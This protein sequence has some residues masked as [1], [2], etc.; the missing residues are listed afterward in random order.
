MKRKIVYIAV[1]VGVIALITGM[2]FYQKS[3]INRNGYLGD[4]VFYFTENTTPLADDSEENE[5]QNESPTK[6]P[7]SESDK[8]T[9]VSVRETSEP[10]N[11]PKPTP[12]PTPTPY[13]YEKII[14]DEK[15]R[16]YDTGTALI[17]ESAYEL[18]NYVGSSASRYAK[19]INT[20]TKKLDSSV[21]V[22]AMVAPTSMGITFPDNKMK[23]VNSSDQKEALENIEK[24][25]SGRE[26]FVPLYDVMMQRRKEYIYFRTDH[27][28]TSLGAYYAYRA[29]CEKKGILPHELSEYKKTSAGDFLGT[30]YRDTNENTNLRTDILEVYYPVNN[31]KLSMEYTTVE[32]S[33]I[34][35][36]V[37]ADAGNY[38][39]SLKYLAFIA[40]DNPYTVIRNKAIKDNSSC[41]VVKESYGNAFVPYLADHYQTIY[42]IDYRY[43]EGKLCDFIKKKKSREVIFINNISMTRNSYLIGKLTQIIS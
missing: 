26:K 1:V 43:W 30:F 25:L 24:K 27:H 11:T 20:L 32:G 19:A 10:R 6:A 22:Y 2:R 37:I 40:G 16:I 38:G 41:I 8:E 36:P 3:L 28:W 33:K 7:K 9:E 23:K 21:Q 17:G 18:Y 13:P 39:T 35:A 42:V 5:P 4:K 15:L 34:S 14:S 29:F 12:V 31:K